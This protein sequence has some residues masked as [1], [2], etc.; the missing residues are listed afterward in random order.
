[1]RDSFGRS[2]YQAFRLSVLCLRKK[3][4]S[5]TLPARSISRSSF[6]AKHRNCWKRRLNR[7]SARS[8][9]AIRADNTMSSRAMNSPELNRHLTVPVFSCF[10]RGLAQGNRV[11][12]SCG[13][14]ACEEIIIPCGDFAFETEAVFA[15][16][17]SDE[18]E[19]DVLERGE[20]GGRMIGADATFVVAED[21]VHHPV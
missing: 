12:E 19:G 7:R 10:K 11:K 18:I 17:F 16:G 14:E 15:G 9:L 21:H 8:A 6:S 4:R 3:T 5:R 2:L 1:M 13:D 20:I